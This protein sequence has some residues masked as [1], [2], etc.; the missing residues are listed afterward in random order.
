MA[1]PYAL[2][3]GTEPLIVLDFKNGVYLVEGDPRT[4]EQIIAENTDYGTFE[5]SHIVADTGL[6]GME[7]GP[8]G[9]NP[10]IIGD[11]L[12][13]IVAGST[14]VM[15]FQ[16]TDDA[17]SGAV[18]ISLIDGVDYNTTYFSRASAATNATMLIDTLGTQVDGA[19][20]SISAHRQALTM[21]DGKIAASVDGGTLYTI[22]PATAW[23]PVPAVFVMGVGAHAILER[24]AIYPPQA[25]GALPGL[26]TIE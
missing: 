3:D 6:V 8:G 26:S 12:T 5:Y 24:I 14:L 2:P 11:P 9:S 20:L 17:G 15:D 16:L 22:S 7:G 23:D 10:L 21:I 13:L 1:S 4:A 25:D 18:T 19:T